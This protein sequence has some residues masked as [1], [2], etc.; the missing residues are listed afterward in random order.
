MA[1]LYGWSS[2]GETF[3]DP[4]YS[5]REEAIV[6]AR[7]DGHNGIIWTARHELVQPAIPFDADDLEERLY[8]QLSDEIG[9]D[10]A[11]GYSMPHEIGESFEKVIVQWM[12]E[13]STKMFDGHWKAVDIM[14]HPSLVSDGTLGNA[15]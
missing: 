1:E 5:T 4:K 8:E 12:K 3:V 14:M 2:G 10:A 11:D 13:Y 9:P 6:A 15:F 7:A